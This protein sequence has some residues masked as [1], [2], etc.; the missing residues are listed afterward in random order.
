MF[1]PV[2]L[3]SC[4]PF[5]EQKVSAAPQVIVALWPDGQ[6]PLTIALALES[7]RSQQRTPAVSVASYRT[8]SLLHSD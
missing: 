5:D 3:Q 4:I 1:S 7:E 2:K 8:A 6:V